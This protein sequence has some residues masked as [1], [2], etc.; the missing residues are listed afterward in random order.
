MTLIQLRQSDPPKWVRIL[1]HKTVLR[2]WCYHSVENE[3]MKGFETKLR[4]WLA[5]ENKKS[6]LDLKNL[7][8]PVLQHPWLQKPRT[9]KEC[10]ACSLGSLTPLLWRQQQ[11]AN[12]PQR[13]FTLNAAAAALVSAHLCCPDGYINTSCD[14]PPDPS[15][16][17]L[18]IWHMG[19]F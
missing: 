14:I 2:L 4:Q 6:P 7:R 5:P 12:W 1:L 8:T 3:L 13:A 16:T 18:W 9:K 11:P 17:H 10:G 19:P 15:R